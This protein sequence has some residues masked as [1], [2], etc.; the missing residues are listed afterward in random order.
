MSLFSNRLSLLGSENAF[1][2]GA[3]IK[4][5]EAEGGDRMIKCNL[6]EPDFATP[7]F[8]IE[9][10]KKQL[11]AGNTHYCNPQGLLSLRQAVA[12]HI[13]ETRNIK[14][15]PERVVIFPGGKPPIGFCQQAYINEGDEIIY[16]SPGYPV[17]ESFIKYVG[18]KPVPLHLKEEKNFSFDGE[19]LARLITSKTKIIFL[20]FPS[21]PTG[22]AASEAQLQEIAQVIKTRCPE[23]IRVYS[24]EIY[25][26]IIFDKGRH[27]SI[28]S[29]P[30]MEDKTIIVSGVSKSYSWTGGR[31]GWAVFPTVE[32]AQVFKNL[33][34]NYFSSLPPYNQEGARV[35]LESAESKKFIVEMMTAFQERRDMV[36]EAL[37]KIPGIT[38]QKPKATFYVF[39]NVAGVCKN[40]GVFDAFDS[41]PEE[42]K[43]K[44]SPS[45]LLQMF[46]LFKYHLAVLD[47]KSFGSLGEIGDEHYL[48]F[49]IATSQEDLKEAMARFQKAAADIDGFNAFFQEG[50]WLF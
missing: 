33:N 20:N 15:T 45:T 44:T 28:A 42:I 25:E 13:N 3:Y 10:V 27:Y 7:K 21:N 22:G 36:V 9:E 24:D 35:A 49:S 18:A 6:G 39:P 41:L 26:D 2:L 12:R 8:I 16:P 48:R 50:K 14:V 29:V 37:N 43:Q 34:I 30:G 47:R 23:D 1:K 5:A 38:C 46:L 11:D 32:E 19:E 40:L 4:K 17:Y 31:I